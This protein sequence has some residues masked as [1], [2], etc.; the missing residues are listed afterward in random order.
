M[1]SHQVTEKLTRKLKMSKPVEFKKRG[2]EKQYQFNE[3]VDEQFG[4]L[5]EE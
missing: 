2:N 3:A 5:E 4:E 1:S